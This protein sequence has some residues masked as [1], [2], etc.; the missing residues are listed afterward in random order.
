MS[1][2]LLLE[3]FAVKLVLG[4]GELQCGKVFIKV[5]QVCYCWKFS[6]I[7]KRNHD[8]VHNLI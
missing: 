2:K 1:S 4:F 7:E 3:E 6:R 8:I 5:I